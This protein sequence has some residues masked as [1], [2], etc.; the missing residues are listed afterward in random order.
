MMKKVLFSIVRIISFAALWVCCTAFVS[1]GKKKAAQEIPELKPES[2]SEFSWY[3]FTQSGF[4]KTEFPDKVPAVLFKPWTEAMRVSDANS[5]SEAGALMLVNRLGVLV[6]SEKQTPAFMQDVRLF[7]T[8]TAGNL[9]FVEKEPVFTLYRSAFFNKDAAPKTDNASP[10]AVVKAPLAAD[11]NRPYIVRIARENTMF[12]PL[13]TY[14]DMNASDSEITGSHFD[15]LTWLSSVKTV[16]PK[17]TEFRYVRW[18][19]I[20]SLLSLSPVTG[21][22]KITETETDKDTYRNAWAPVSF[23]QAPLRLRQLL[24]DIPASI[25][26]S[27][28]CKTAGGH[29]PRSF[30]HG[31]SDTAIEST[32]VIA[33]SWICAVFADGTTYFSGALENRFIVNEGK[34]FAFRLPKLP[35]GFRYS[36]F[37]ISGDYLAAGWEESN[38]YQTGRSG[39]AVVNLAKVLYEENKISNS[40]ARK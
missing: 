20:G 27:V 16:T 1:C 39:F 5:D 17:K 25:T 28:T 8:A 24:S 38:F 18:Q 35:D 9:I 3:S 29:S 7:G 22:G 33:P 11:V 13:L 6:F 4:A 34:T 31:A 32:A 19:S 37:C 15:G 36:D 14:G 30:V 10:S 40:G 26:Y 23:S 12:Y 21:T 2:E